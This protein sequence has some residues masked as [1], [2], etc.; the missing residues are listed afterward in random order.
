MCPQRGIAESDDCVISSIRI[1]ATH[2]LPRALAPVSWSDSKSPRPGWWLT[3]RGLPGSAR[4]RSVFG[5]GNVK[6]GSGQ[7]LTYY[8]RAVVWGSGEVMEFEWDPVKNSVN[9]AKHGISF[10]AASRIFDD[11]GHVVLDSTRPGNGERRYKAVG[12]IGDKLFTVIFTERGANCRIISARRSRS[13]ERRE[14]DQGP[15]G[16]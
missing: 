10:V 7:H 12:I 15:Q 4:R 13:D 11:P 16:T 8:C 1:L 5:L 3:N 6:K 9:L 2:H 14:Y